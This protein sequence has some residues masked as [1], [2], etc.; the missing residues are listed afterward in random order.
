MQWVNFQC[1]DS[2][3]WIEVGVCESSHMLDGNWFSGTSLRSFSRAHT[4]ALCMVHFVPVRR[5]ANSFSCAWMDSLWR[6]IA[7]RRLASESSS[8]GLS[9][10]I[11]VVLN[12]HRYI[13]NF[14]NFL[15]FPLSTS[16]YRRCWL[17]THSE[18]EVWNAHF[19]DRKKINF[20]KNAQPMYVGITPIFQFYKFA[21]RR[22]VKDPFHTVRTLPL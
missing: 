6:D 13:M 4:G 14:D 8:E 22:S 20:K 1:A 9:C 2:L 18:K 17:W 3:E 7:H 5:N 19:T 11:G 21:F 12:D 16:W 15:S 10:S